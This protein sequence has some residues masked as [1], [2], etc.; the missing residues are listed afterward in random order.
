MV[1]G[2]PWFIESNP[3]I[4]WREGTIHFDNETLKPIPLSVVYDGLDKIDIHVM[5]A[6]EL[7][8]A[9]KKNPD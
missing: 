2:L 5:S 8:E 7:R 3:M 4:N 6:T 9:I 1:L